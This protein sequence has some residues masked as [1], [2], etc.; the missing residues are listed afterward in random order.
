MVLYVVCLNEINKYKDYSNNV[1]YDLVDRRVVGI[2]DNVN[3]A[4]ILRDALIKL[5]SD[6]ADALDCSEYSVNIIDCELNDLEYHF[7]D[8][9]CIGDCDNKDILSKLKSLLE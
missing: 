5:E 3:S 4:I 1:R 7:V 6:I 2:F 9:I 8:E